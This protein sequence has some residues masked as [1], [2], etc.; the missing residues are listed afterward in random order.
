MEQHAAAVEELAGALD[1]PGWRYRL[2]ARAT[3]LRR[4]VADAQAQSERSGPA[5]A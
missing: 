1:D 4:L 5:G 3:D 2:R